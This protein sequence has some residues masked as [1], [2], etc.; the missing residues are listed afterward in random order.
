MTETEI[1]ELQRSALVMYLGIDALYKLH[2]EVEVEG[3]DA[4]AHCSAIADG[5]V[6][7]PCP[8]VQVLLTDFEELVDEAEEAQE[9]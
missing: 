3:S 8:S 6:A 5:I 2:A 1:Q 4:C 7:Y 9:A